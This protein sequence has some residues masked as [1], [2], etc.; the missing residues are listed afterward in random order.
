MD[1]SWLEA[2]SKHWHNGTLVQAVTQAA[3]GIGMDIVKMAIVAV[4]SSLISIAIVQER[5]QYNKESI[6]EVKARLDRDERNIDYNKDRN[7]MQEGEFQLILQRLNEI[8]A[9]IKLIDAEH[10][11]IED[12]QRRQKRK[13]KE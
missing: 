4:V 8:S 5:A 10:S 1:F 9:H 12:E 6:A 3:S 11:R 2:L 7:T 13:D